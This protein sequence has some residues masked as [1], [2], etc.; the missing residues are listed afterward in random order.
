MSTT[1]HDLQNVPMPVWY[2]ICAAVARVVG[3]ALLVGS[4]WL[5]INSY[6]TNSV[7]LA[8]GFFG[9]LALLILP[10]LPKAYL[11]QRN[12]MRGLRDGSFQEFID[13][14]KSKG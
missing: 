5:H 7:C 1:P 4:A 10:S 11:E 13:D 3:F 6:A 12:R 8:I 14:Q 2:R 9:G